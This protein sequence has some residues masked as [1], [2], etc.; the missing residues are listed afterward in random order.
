MATFSDFEDQETY[1]NTAVAIVQEAGNRLSSEAFSLKSSREFWVK[2]NEADLV[3][4]TDIS[5]QEYIFGC[6]RE[7]FP[8][9]S[10][11][12]EE[13]AGASENWRQLLDHGVVWVLDPVDGTTNWIHKFPFVCISLALVVEGIVQVAVVYDVHRKKLFHACRGRGAFCDEKNL[14]VSTIKRL[15][16]ALVITEFGYVRD[17]NGLSNILQV[18]HELLLYG[19]HGIRQTGCGVLDL[20][21]LASGQVDALYV[22]IG[23]EGWKPWDYAAGY[24]IVKEAGGTVYSLNDEEFHLCSTS[25]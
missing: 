9:H 20:C 18:L 15:K 7:S 1:W 23:G 22:G 12:G 17:E 4:A 24:L 19:I 16:E 6:L 2:T 25:I 11:F 21:L 8:E 14:N 10:L 3:S 5:I 13:N